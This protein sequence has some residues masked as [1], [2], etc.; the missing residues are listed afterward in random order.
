MKKI[1]N[2]GIATT[3]VVFIS[4]FLVI[5]GTAGFY[6]YN[7]PKKSPAD[8]PPP[9]ES[10]PEIFDANQ[11][12]L[13]PPP[14]E[15]TQPPKYASTPTN[16]VQITVKQS[17]GSAML[18]A[19][20]EDK[21]YITEKANYIIE[22]IVEKVES[23]WNNERTSIFTYTDLQI[24]KYVKGTSFTENKLQITT[25][26][27][28]IGGIGQS[29]EDQP[30]FHQGKRVRIYFQNTNGEFSMVCAQAGVEEI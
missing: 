28:E 18:I 3:G 29:V 25:P 15:L 4:I 21:S 9:T 16:K 30:I 19:E 2:Q 6:L 17:G 11:L 8:I 10:V 12:P 20:C 27:G 1:N 22:G 7:S 5:L 23:R 13:L 26:G 14:P 24:E